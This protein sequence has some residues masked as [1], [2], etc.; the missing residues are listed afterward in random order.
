MIMW[1]SSG[2]LGL[3]QSYTIFTLSWN[4]RMGLLGKVV[5]YAHILQQDDRTRLRQGPT[6]LFARPTVDPLLCPPP[7]HTVTTVWTSCWAETGPWAFA[8]SVSGVER[9]SFCGSD[10]ER[11]KNVGARIGV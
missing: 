2:Y 8:R 6:I 11:L 3:N 4:A 7:K 10:R 9:F 5:S 1:Q